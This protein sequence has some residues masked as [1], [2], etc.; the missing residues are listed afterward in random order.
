MNVPLLYSSAARPHKLCSRVA[1]D[2]DR[3]DVVLTSTRWISVKP[4]SCIGDVVPLARQQDLDCWICGE[5]PIEADH[6]D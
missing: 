2:N 1:R 3:A 6:L 4:E 5:K